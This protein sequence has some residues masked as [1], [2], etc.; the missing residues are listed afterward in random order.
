MI[1]LVFYLFI[2]FSQAQMSGDFGGAGGGAVRLG[3]SVTACSTS[4]QG[5]VKYNSGDGSLYFCDG[6]N[7][8]MAFTDPCANSLPNNWDFTDLTGQTSLTVVTSSIHQ[9]VNIAGCSVAVK[10]TGSVGSP[11]YRICDDATCTTVSQDWTTSQGVI[12]N[13]KYI[14]LRLTTRE[15]ASL[16]TV[17]TVNIGDRV[18]SWNVTT[19]ADCTASEPVVGSFC[20]DGSIYIGRGPDGGTKVYTTACSSGLS[21]DGSSC[22]G[23]G[24]YLPWAALGGSVSTGNFGSNGETMT[25]NLAGL[26]NADAPYSAAVYCNNLTFHGQ[27]DWYLPSLSEAS[28]LQS[29][30]AVLPDAGCGNATRF[31]SSTELS[32]GNAWY[33]RYDATGGTSSAKTIFYAIHCIR[34]D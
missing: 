5:T 4:I 9:V 3:G 20:S 14:Q 29:A 1:L 23:N 13:N 6:Y 21:W 26:S 17:A 32:A 31:W 8:K 11:E 16:T 22:T 30:C 18:E 34:K 2:Y 24:I 15:M 28:L 12:T 25:S 19:A 10:I 7:W 27:S 33:Y